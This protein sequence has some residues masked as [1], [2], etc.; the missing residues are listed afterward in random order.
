MGLGSGEEMIFDPIDVRDVR[1]NAS[2]A[3]E[4]WYFDKMSKAIRLVFD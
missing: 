4:G 2:S 1:S 3:I